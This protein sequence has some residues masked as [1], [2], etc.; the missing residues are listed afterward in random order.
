MSTAV[1]E[2]N[3][4][5]LRKLIY[6]SIEKMNT[7]ELQEVRGFISQKAFHSLTEII[8]RGWADGVIT[9]EK[10]DVAVKNYRSKM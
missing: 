9:D 3:R 10:L 2:K 7:D 4:T 1:V 5:E 6:T 8:T